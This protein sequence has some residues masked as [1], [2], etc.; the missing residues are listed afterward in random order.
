MKASLFKARKD[1]DFVV[2]DEA[3][4]HL[5]S[6]DMVRHIPAMSSEDS[7]APERTE[8]VVNGVSHYTDAPYE[9][10]LALLNGSV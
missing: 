6:I 2:I 7:Y 5:S 3:V 10:V 8:L 1:F 4:I 9:E